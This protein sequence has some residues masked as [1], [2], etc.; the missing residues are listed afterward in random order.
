[1]LLVL[2]V[3]LIILFFYLPC[4]KQP[5]VTFQELYQKKMLQYRCQTINLNSISTINV[6][7]YGNGRW[8]MFYN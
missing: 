3:L 7:A 5:Q 1:M 2:L 4:N 8:K 6:T